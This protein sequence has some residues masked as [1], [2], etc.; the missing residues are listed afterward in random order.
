MPLTGLAPSPDFAMVARA[1]RAHAE[2]VERGQDLPAALDRAIDV[3]TTQRRQ[4]LLDIR[5]AP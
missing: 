1:S 3:A 2:V 5:T 4:C